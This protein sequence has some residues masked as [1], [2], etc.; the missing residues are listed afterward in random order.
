MKTVDIVLRTQ[1]SRG[2]RPGKYGGPD[3]YVSAVIR[4]VESEPVRGH[5]LSQANIR[6]YGW[7]II[8]CGEG[9]SKNSGPR[10]ALGKA[11]ALANVVHAS[12]NGKG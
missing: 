3:T 1:K 4:D 10:S 9:Y 8:H 6:K 5:P 7:E 2:S 12:F 11:I